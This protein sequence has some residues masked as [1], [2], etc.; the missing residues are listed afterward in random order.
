VS[1]VRIKPFRAVRFELNFS[2]PD[3]RAKD[4]HA[5]RT[6]MGHCGVPAAPPADKFVLE[7]QECLARADRSSTLLALIFRV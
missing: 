3:D 6:L 4:P 1:R 2:R 5:A 7:A